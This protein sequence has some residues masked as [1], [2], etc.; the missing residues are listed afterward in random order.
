[1]ALIRSCLPRCTELPLLI[2]FASIESSDA[3]LLF[4]RI[5]CSTYS[6]CCKFDVENYWLFTCSGFSFW[7]V[8]G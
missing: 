8:S 5:T 4:L 6:A 2:V 1:M 3:L 7:K